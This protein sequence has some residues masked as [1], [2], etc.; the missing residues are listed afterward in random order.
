[1]HQMSNA[2]NTRKDNR[3]P[4]LNSC[5]FLFFFQKVLEGEGGEGLAKVN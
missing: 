1:M 5:H 2:E 4:T 3:L